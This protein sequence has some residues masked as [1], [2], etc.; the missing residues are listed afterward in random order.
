MH[1]ILSCC[2]CMLSTAYVT[3]QKKPKSLLSKFHTCDKLECLISCLLG[4]QVRSISNDKTRTCFNMYW[5]LFVCLTSIHSPS[6][7]P[8]RR[9]GR[10]LNDQ[11]LRRPSEEWRVP[12]P[13][14]RGLQE[15]GEEGPPGAGGPQDGGE[16]PQRVREAEPGYETVMWWSE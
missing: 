8:A 3:P 2:M 15:C 11:D 4:E 14:Q 7:V 16:R 13:L 12:R 5:V 9:G 6:P 10:G 1:T